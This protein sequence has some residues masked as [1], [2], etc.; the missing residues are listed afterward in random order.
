[1]PSQQC[2]PPISDA[3]LIRAFAELSNER[4]Q[5]RP[6]CSVKLRSLMQA[7]IRAQGKGRARGVLGRWRDRRSVSSRPVGGLRLAFAIACVSIAL[8]AVGVFAQ[9]LYP[10]TRGTQ[11][12][13]MAVDAGEVTI[14]RSLHVFGDVALTRRL[15]AV[16]GGDQA[17][18]VSD[19]VTSAEDTVAKITFSDGSRTTLGPGTHLVMNR[20]QARTASSHLAIAMRLE[21]GSLQTEVVHLRPEVDEFTLSTPD[22]EANVKGTIFH[23]DVR[24][25]GT[26]LSTQEGT[27][28]VSWDGQIADVAAGQE[29]EVL[30]AFLSQSPPK[31]RAQAP[32]LSLTS[33]LSDGALQ[34]A[35]DGEQIVYL[36]Q[37]TL[38]WRI[39]SQPGSSVEIYVNDALVKTIETDSNGFASLDFSPTAEGI[40]RLSAI[41]VTLDGEKSRPSSPFVVAFDLTQPSVVLT[42]PAEPQ[43]TSK[44]VV[45]A[46][47]TEPGVRLML[48]GQPLAVDDSG[49]F[50]TQL[51]LALGSNELTIEAI[52]RADNTVKLQSV[53]IRK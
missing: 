6:E 39:D 41:A 52:D 13:Q 2:Y 5:L 45:V 33:E 9:R 11:V 30:Q 43:V 29:L 34:T 42:S 38:S 12:A 18:R 19:Q 36:N 20:L 22:L 25:D 15:V 31:P 3:D 48:N 51:P 21:S 40:Y 24:P 44:E 14:I 32:R 4:V 50:Q 35:E 17:L 1:M 10:A 37:P 27:V 26:R 47:Q 46:G 8:L 23:I 53:I 7:E 49:N 16:P 28:R